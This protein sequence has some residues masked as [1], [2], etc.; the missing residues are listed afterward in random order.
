MELFRQLDYKLT[1]LLT[2][3]L[4]EL[5]LKSLSRLKRR[6]NFTW[7]N[8]GKVPYCQSSSIQELSKQGLK[9]FQHCFH[10]QEIIML[11]DETGDY[12]INGWLLHGS[13]IDSTEFMTTRMSFKII[14]DWIFTFW[15]KNLCLWIT[16]GEAW[17]W[18][19]ALHYN[20][21]KSN[22]C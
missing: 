7:W 9:L 6:G 5:F 11:S 18:I 3:G 17:I 12:V 21:V 15:R 14:Q 20:M 1:Y 13:F 10:N 4:T 8:P 19:L 2:Y 16:W 22:H